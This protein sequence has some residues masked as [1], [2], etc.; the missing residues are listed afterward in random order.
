MVTS[1][2]QVSKPNSFCDRHPLIYSPDLKEC[3]CPLSKDKREQDRDL[4]TYDGGASEAKSELDG[5]LYN[6]I[7][8]D[9]INYK[10]KR[11]QESDLYNKTPHDTTHFPN[12]PGD[13]GCPPPRM[14]L[15]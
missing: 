8:G 13:P 12:C 3:L 2:L 1:P 10:A 4:Y 6:Y 9:S 11:E 14:Q 15:D 7:D 5:D